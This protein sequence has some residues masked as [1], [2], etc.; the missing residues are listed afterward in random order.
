MLFRSAAMIF[1]NPGASLAPMVTVR[2]QFVEA[3]RNHNAMTKKEAEAL[4]L[5]EVRRLHLKDPESILA[6]RP[7]QLS[8]GMKQRVAIGLTLAMN[9]DLIL[10]DEPVSAL[11]VATQ[12]TIIEALRVRRR[13]RNTAIIMVSHN[14]C[15]CARVADR[16]LVMRHGRIVDEGVTEAILAR[17]GDTYSGQLLHSVSHLKGVQFEKYRQSA[18]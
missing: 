17:S 18:G 3:I 8:G 9:P 4:A 11:D 14:I 6:A 13:E 1:Q 12:E 5:E 2:R 16:I 15:A 10:A 7:W